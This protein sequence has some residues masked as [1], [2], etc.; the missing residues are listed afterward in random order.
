MDFH[1]F[2]VAAIDPKMLLTERHLGQ[3]FDLLDTENKGFLNIKNFMTIL[4]TN[5]NKGGVTRDKMNGPLFE[6]NESK[7]F[8]PHY[9][10]VKERW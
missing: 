10:K 5:C 9:D 6:V 2:L 4:P 3:L 7:T 8:K 1:E